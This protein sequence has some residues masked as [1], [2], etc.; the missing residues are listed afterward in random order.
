MLTHFKPHEF[1]HM[2]RMD[3]DFLQ[4]VD[5]FRAW[6]GFPTLLTSDYRDSDTSAHGEGLAL[7]M[8]L[9][10]P[11]RWADKQPDWFTIWQVA[12]QFGF[13]GIGVYFDWNAFGKPVIGLHVDDSQR[14]ARPLSWVRISGRY[15]YFRHHNGMFVSP[16]GRSISPKD[17]FTL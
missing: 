9:Y 13:R 11:K 4:K 7:D 16:D 1:N 14:N 5:A 10:T 6:H 17:F 2:T 12:H 3:A 8:V 15:Y